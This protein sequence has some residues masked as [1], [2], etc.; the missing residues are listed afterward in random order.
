MFIIKSLCFPVSYHFCSKAEIYYAYFFRFLSH[1]FKPIQRFFRQQFINFALIQQ[2]VDNIY[3][4][5][6]KKELMCLKF[7]HNSSFAIKKRIDKGLLIFFP[8]IS[9]G[10]KQYHS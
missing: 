10:N 5:R 9:T 3:N 4:Q 2:S 8:T 6:K 7:A 1:T